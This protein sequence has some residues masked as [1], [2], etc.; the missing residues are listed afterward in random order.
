MNSP[1]LKSQNRVNILLAEWAEETT[2]W[3]GAIACELFWVRAETAEVAEDAKML[4]LR[5]ISFFNF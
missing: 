3:G 5:R 2:L 4:L 1:G